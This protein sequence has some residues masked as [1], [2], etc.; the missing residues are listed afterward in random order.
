MRKKLK[1]DEQQYFTWD[2][3]MSQKDR[4]GDVPEIF[5]ACSRVR[6]PGK[7]T[8]I[9]RQ[10]LAQWRGE[11]CPLVDLIGTRRKICILT[12]TKQMLG[13]VAQ[14][15][16]SSAI[17]VHYPGLQVWETIQAKT[18][19]EI[20]LRTPGKTDVDPPEE[21]V[22]GYVIPLNS[23]KTVKEISG[24]F[25]D[26]GVM[27]LD[28]FIAPDN[29]YVPDYVNKIIDIHN[30]IA[31]GPDPSPQADP[32]RGRYVPLFLAANCITQ[33]NPLF[34]DLDLTQHLQNDTRIFRGV[35]CIYQRCENTF[36]VGKQAG[37]R[38][39]QAFSRSGYL[40]SKGWMIDDFA[41]C[42]R[43]SKSWGRAYY[44]A[45]LVVEGAK[46]GAYWYPSNGYLYIC[47]SVDETCPHVYNATIDGA[48]NVPYLR[49]GGWWKTLRDSLHRGLVRFQ[50]AQCARAVLYTCR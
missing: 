21:E 41:A 33:D 26:V 15:T 38:F 17:A 4:N 47:H 34:V 10:M 27:F 23:R 14:G 42:E 16:L 8:D 46:Y 31:R 50:D 3:I 5:M 39:N 45:T 44:D 7:T 40:G 19:S 36:A 49:T 37:S 29:D 35:G 1:L 18:Y 13:T 11:P 30:S 24:L 12:P 6:G 25:L 43:P 2:Y 22:I 20:H 32:E 9:G 28:E 48:P